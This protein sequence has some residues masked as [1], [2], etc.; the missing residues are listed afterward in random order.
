MLAIELHRFLRGLLP[1]ALVTLLDILHEGL[2]SAHGFDLPALLYRQ[3]DKRETHQ[4]SESN[5]GY[6][7]VQE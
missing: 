3:R 2:T 4:Q 1:V 5:D 7:K 6:A